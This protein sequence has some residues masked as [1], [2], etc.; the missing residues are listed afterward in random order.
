[1]SYVGALTLSFQERGAFPEQGGS[2]GFLSLQEPKGGNLGD[3]TLHPHSG[4]DSSDFICVFHFEVLSVQR[5]CGFKNTY[6]YI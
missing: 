5:A 6:I 1:M 2:L 4:Q 3:Q